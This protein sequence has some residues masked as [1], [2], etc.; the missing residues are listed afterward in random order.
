M[1]TGKAVSRALCGHFLIEAALTNKLLVEVWPHHSSTTSLQG[2]N[3]Q[4]S[5]YDLQ[6][7]PIR[8]SF[9]NTETQ[10][11]MESEDII[12]KLDPIEAEK[13]VIYMREFYHLNLLVIQK[14]YTSLISV[15]FST[16]HFYVRNLAQ[17]NSG[18]SISDIIIESRK[19]RQ[20]EFA[21]D[22]SGKDVKCV[23]SNW[24]VFFRKSYS[25]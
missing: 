3:S 6:E 25:Y 11:N 7:E 21:F 8:P 22:S 4:E 15:Y 18:C 14:H 23:C 17:P 9:E 20:L 10:E 13:F 24:F 1:I 5:A 12:S 2:N 19:N 16:K